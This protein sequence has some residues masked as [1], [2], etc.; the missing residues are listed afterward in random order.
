VNE[1]FSREMEIIKTVEMLEIK[2]SI[3]KIKRTMDSLIS[4]QD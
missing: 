3:Y 4:R 1:R 2:T